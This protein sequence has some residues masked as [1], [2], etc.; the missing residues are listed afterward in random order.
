[1]PLTRIERNW[2][3]RSAV[4][5]RSA[6]CTVAVLPVP[7]VP[8]MYRE[9]PSAP[10]STAARSVAITSARSFS[11]HGMRSGTADGARRAA[12]SE[13]RPRR[14]LRPAP[15]VGRPEEPSSP[16]K[17]FGAYCGT[18]RIAAAAGGAL[19]S[20]SWRPP[21]RAASASVLAPVSGTNSPEPAWYMARHAKVVSSSSSS[22]AGWS[23]QRWY[24]SHSMTVQ[25][26]SIVSTRFSSTCT[27]SKSSRGS[28]PTSR[29]HVVSSG[30]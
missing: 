12:A 6:W 4:S 3:V 29:P 16:R 14:R 25:W 20:C 10:S 2:S 22:S 13:K 5:S 8:E 28:W 23:S 18:A 21:M 11:R 26:Q 19:W 17:A 15:R 27:V 30:V 24:A 7:G 1:M 9:P